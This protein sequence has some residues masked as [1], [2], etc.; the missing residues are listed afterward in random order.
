MMRITEGSAARGS[1]ASLQSS[2]SRLAILQGQLSSGRLITKPSDSPSGTSTALQLRAELSRMGQYQNNAS[3]GLGWLTSVDTTLGSATDRM[4]QVRTLVLQGLNTG[5]NDATSNEALAQQVD[6]ARS[7]LL[8]LANTPYMGRPIFGGTTAGANAFNADGTYAGDT[9]TVSR[10]VAPN[11]EVQI[12]SSGTA[13]FG[14]N[15]DNVFD[16]LSDIAAKL[17]TDP[18]ALGPDLDKIDAAQ[19]RLSGQQA[20]GGAR[21]QRVQATQTAAVTTTIALKSQLSELQDIDL[22]TTAI[23][24]A[25]ADAAYQASLATTAKIRQI[26]LLDYLR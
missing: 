14:P 3:D 20:L 23:E 9:A 13:A 4:H 12:N 11:T 8:S 19:L 26:S 18:S 21:Y 16:L 15:G 6:A 1:L 10:T 17:R 2:A 25:T 24:M 22:P 5:A 7:S